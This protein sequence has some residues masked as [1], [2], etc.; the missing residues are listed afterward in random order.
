MHYQVTSL[1]KSFNSPSA[2]IEISVSDSFSSFSLLCLLLLLLFFVCFCCWFDL[3]CF[4]FFFSLQSSFIHSA[5]LSTL[6]SMRHCLFVA[7]ASSSRWNCNQKVPM[8]TDLSPTETTH[9]MM[10]CTY[11]KQILSTAQVCNM[12]CQNRCQ[13]NLLWF[14]LCEC[15]NVW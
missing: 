12:K 6:L 2:S 14:E 13:K 4:F 7:V 3:V 1:C 15:N 8:I 10:V 11:K 9:S 5:F